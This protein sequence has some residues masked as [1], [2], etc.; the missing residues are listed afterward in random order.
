MLQV[1]AT[2]NNLKTNKQIIKLREQKGAYRGMDNYQRDFSDVNRIVIKVGSSSLTHKETGRLDLVKLETLVRQLSNLRNMGKEVVLVSSGAIMVGKGALN[3]EHRPEKVEEKQGCAAVGQA[4]LMMIY[5]RLFS[6]YNQIIGQ[7]L[8]TKSNV[9]HPVSRKN[10]RN[11]FNQ[12]LSQGVIPIVNENDT[13]ATDEIEEN[14]VFG[15]NDTLSA[16]VTKLIDGQ[17]LILLSDIDGLY[18]DDPRTNPEAQFIQEVT[19]ISD[20]LKAMAKGA[21]SKVGTGG[22]ATKLKAAEIATES[23]ASMII[24]NGNS[25]EIIGQLVDGQPMGTLFLSK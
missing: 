25:M 23:G 5:Q 2:D 3:L 8:I 9:Q 1:K 16:E 19:K 11:T 18:T 6:Q 22:M 15:D 13:V 17:L 10:A 20:E 24:A 14:G 4:R 12:L 21:G 7:I